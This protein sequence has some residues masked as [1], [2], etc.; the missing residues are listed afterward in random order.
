MGLFIRLHTFFE[1][2]PSCIFFVGM[3]A[4]VVHNGIT[5]DITA[6]LHTV[7]IRFIS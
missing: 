5:G 6:I 4:D 3:C 2:D 1:L 7:T